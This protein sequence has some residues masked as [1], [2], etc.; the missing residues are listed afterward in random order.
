[1]LDSISRI[2]SRCGTPE[3]TLPPTELYNEAWVLRLLLDYFARNAPMEHPLSPAP[4]ARWA[5]EVLLSSQFSPRWQGDACAALPTAVQSS[6]GMFIALAGKEIR[7][8]V[9]AVPPKA[10]LER[11]SAQHTQGAQ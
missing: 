9:I 5:S 7:Y 2:L 10:A 1:M 6:R 3:G 11:R 4:G 8:F